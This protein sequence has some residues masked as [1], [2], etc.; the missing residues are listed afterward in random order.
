[1]A[2]DSTG[3]VFSFNGSTHGNVAALSW[4]WGGGYSESRSVAF[5]HEIGTVTISSFDA[6]STTVWATAGS[7]VVTGG[8]VGLTATAVCTDVGA[9]A[10]L[11]GVTRY[12]ATFQLIQ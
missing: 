1:M 10:Q 2:T 9:E 7:L 5:K 12:S 6:I 3:V 4:S 8:G 11:N